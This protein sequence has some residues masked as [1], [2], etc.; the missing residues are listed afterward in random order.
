MESRLNSVTFGREDR[1]RRIP[2]YDGYLIDING[3]VVSCYYNPPRVM[4]RH[5]KGT[6][7]ALVGNDGTLKH[8]AINKL[9][10]SVFPEFRPN[11]LPDDAAPVPGYEYYF[12]RP[13]GHVWSTQQSEPRRLTPI[14]H[15]D[16]G[17]QWVTM[18]DANRKRTQLRVDKLVEVVFPQDSI[19]DM[20]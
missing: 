12:I 5:K 15:S 14:M 19:E 17:A 20:M 2:G 4:V 9:V 6:I 13:C 11:G 3:K 1:I 16:T 7:V 18:A 8:A 10:R